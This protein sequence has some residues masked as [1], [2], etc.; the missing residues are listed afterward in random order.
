MVPT[1]SDGDQIV[2]PPAQLLANVIDDQVDIAFLTND[3]G[4]RGAINGRGGGKNNR[5]DAV[6]PLPP[7]QRR[8]QGRQVAIKQHRVLPCALFSASAAAGNIGSGHG[9]KP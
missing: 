9:H 8:R 6:H 1:T 4:K 7:A 2:G 5:L 3:T